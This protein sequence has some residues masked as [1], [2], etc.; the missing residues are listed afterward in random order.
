MTNRTQRS[1]VANVLR[2]RTGAALVEF[3][4][5]LPALLLLVF[6]IIQM[7]LVAFDYIMVAHAA[8]VGARTFAYSRND[9]N[10]Y[11]DT[12]SAINTAS[13]FTTSQI[14][15]LTITLSVCTAYG[16]GSDSCSTWQTCS[17]TSV[18]TCQSALGAAWATGETP[19]YPVSVNVSYNCAG[20]ISIMPTYLINL[21]GF[22]PMTSTMLQPVQ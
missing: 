12:V 17:S 4:F 8:S 20:A 9:T 14:A 21:T 10:A 6:G 3:T 1:R 16:S 22:C 18:P 5:V 13:S 15:D 19:P 2:D 11:S 7:G